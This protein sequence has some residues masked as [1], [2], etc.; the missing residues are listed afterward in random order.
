MFQRNLKFV[1]NNNILLETNTHKMP[2]QAY[3][4]GP[5]NYPKRFNFYESGGSPF[6]LEKLIATIEHNK[7][8]IQSITLAWY[9]YNNKKLHE[10]LRE[11]STTGILI[12]VITIP[13]EGYD[14]QNPKPLI[15]KKTGVK[16]TR[17]YTKYA[18][19]KAIFSEAYH[20]ADCPNYQLHFFPHLYVRSHRVKK[21]S[22]GN[23]PYS[24][25]LKGA[26]ITKKNGFI[27]ALS[28][29]NLAV[30]D[31]VKQESMVFIEDEP[32]YL[33]STQTFFDHLLANSIP[34]TSFTAQLNTSKNNY[35]FCRSNNSTECFFTAP[36][37][38]DS[39]NDLEKRIIP[40]INKATRRIIICAQHLAAYDYPFKAAFHS[41]QSG[42]VIRNGLLGA[43]IAK[44]KLGISTTCLSQT[45]V[46]SS[47]Q[48]AQFS[49]HKFRRPANTSNFKAFYAALA[50]APQANYF[51]NANIHSKF[52]IIDDLLIYCTYNFTPTQFIFLDKVKIDR[53]DEMPDLTYEG[54]HCEVGAHVI[55]KEP[56]I[57]NAFLDNVALI[58]RGKDTVKVL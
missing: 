11:L 33:E 44:A 9:L 58:V 25:H 32:E 57:L 2:Y 54:I 17:V 35:A 22:R 49:T 38:F 12:N 10:Y 6:L 34:L 27:L 46:P 55:I 23:L 21:F 48:K 24:L 13:L 30:R 19:A 45:F 18:L 37:Y 50:T 20:A 51:V 3:F 41:T 28:S 40:I 47:E 16:T 26:F 53:F 15:T 42:R 29:S 7:Q 8:D 52:I 1:E 5:H 36:F 39:A 56:S 4:D 43:I 31:L 14:N